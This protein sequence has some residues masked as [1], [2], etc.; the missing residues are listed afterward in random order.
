MLT[1]LEDKSN[2]F[3]GLAQAH[4]VTQKASSQQPTEAHHLCAVANRDLYLL[5][6]KLV[7]CNS[8]LDKSTTHEDADNL[9]VPHGR[10]SHERASDRGGCLIGRCLMGVYL[11]GVYLLGVHLTGVYLRGVRLMGIHFMA[12]TSWACISRACTP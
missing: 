5:A 2:E 11:M 9:F 7:F 1:Y 12:C 10:A 6:Q 4:A 3:P 8:Y